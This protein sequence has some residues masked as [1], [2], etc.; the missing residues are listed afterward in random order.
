MMDTDVDVKSVG[1]E[2]EV[3]EEAT[4]GMEIECPV[5]IV[6]LKHDIL[7]T[8]SSLTLLTEGTC[9]DSLLTTLPVRMIC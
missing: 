7:Q 9:I 8:D 4:S 6:H 1:V 5:P 2:E 3:G